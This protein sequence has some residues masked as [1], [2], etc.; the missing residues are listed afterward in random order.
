MTS[1]KDREGIKT[2]NDY[3]IRITGTYYKDKDEF[4]WIVAQRFWENIKDMTVAEFRETPLIRGIGRATRRKILE[5]IKRLH[6][7]AICNN[8][9][10]PC[11]TCE[12]AYPQITR[13]EPYCSYCE[14]D[15]D[16][17]C[18]IPDT[19]VLEGI[20]AKIKEMQSQN[21][22]RYILFAW[23][24]DGYLNRPCGGTSDIRGTYDT[25]QAAIKSFRDLQKEY[26]DIGCEWTGSVLDRFTGDIAYIPQK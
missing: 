19:E 12:E 10:I 7:D 16:E 17:Y 8:D 20:V 22:K 18:P 5:N 2:L 6:E 4:K 24:D 26:S 21:R 13:E 14:V 15:M 1:V 23:S 9:W 11:K 3:G 25:P